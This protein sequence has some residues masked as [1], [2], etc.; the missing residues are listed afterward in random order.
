MLLHRLDWNKSM[1][2]GQGRENIQNLILLTIDKRLT[3][4]PKCK[5]TVLHLSQPVTSLLR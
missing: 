2:L 1:N 3:N 4:R 5:N